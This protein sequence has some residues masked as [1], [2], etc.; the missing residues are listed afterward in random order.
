MGRA[1]S[2][3]VSGW[4]AAHEGMLLASSRG[5]AGRHRRAGAGRAAAL[6]VK[7]VQAVPAV[8]VEPHAHQQAEGALVVSSSRR[9]LG[10][11]HAKVPAVPLVRH[12]R[13]GGSTAGGAEGRMWMWEREL[14]G[15]D[16]RPAG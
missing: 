14:R 13:G 7:L 11:V 4:P 15:E 9:I 3:G 10:F 8:H 12:L 2:G 6:E 16:R 5:A 1:R